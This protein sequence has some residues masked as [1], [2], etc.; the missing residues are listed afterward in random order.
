MTTLTEFTN[1]EAQ[2]LIGGD[3]ADGGARKP[4]V[5]PATGEQIGSVPQGSPSDV[6][7]AV[8]AARRAAGPWAAMT[9]FQR[10]EA[11]KRLG[12]VVA[13]RREELA[14]TLSLEQGKPYKTEALGEVDSVIGYIE[15]AAQNAIALEG[16]MPPSNDPAKRVFIYR[17]PRGV[18]GAIQPWNYPLETIGIQAIPGLACGNTAVCVPAPTTS[19]SAYAFAKCFEEAELPPGVFNLVTGEGPVVGDAL[20]G[21]PGIDAILFTGSTATGRLVA[22][23]AAGKPQLLELGGNGPFVIL[24]DADLKLAVPAAVL[25]CYYTAGQQ[26]TAA[27]RILVH[28]RVYDEFVDRLTS[29]VRQEIRL[30]HPLDEQ[31]SMGPLNNEKVAAKMDAHVADALDRG[32]DLVLGGSRDAGWPTDL[33]WQPTIVTGVTDPMLIANE[34]TFGPVAPLQA[35]SSE[36]QALAITDASPY[37]LSTAVFTRDLARGLR[38][39]ERASSG[40]VV[41][42]DATVWNELHIPF[43]GAPGKGS[44]VGRAQGRFPMETVFTELKTVFAHIG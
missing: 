36:E 12:S 7:R 2:L 10:V 34:E 17:R 9:V 8:T 33:Y 21:H 41:I 11:L 38:Y 27:E 24:D 19:L 28:E 40:S 15:L 31:T 23:R 6:D 35:I 16:V 26:C 13:A 20:S 18:I 39:A 4:I 44:G 1:V 37:G 42:N 30:G 29:A 14:L 32:A 5:S 25:A 22:Q 43:G 3:W